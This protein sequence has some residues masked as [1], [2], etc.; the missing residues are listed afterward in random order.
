MTQVGTLRG[1]GRGGH[2]VCGTHEN[3]CCSAES[4]ADNLNFRIY[5]QIAAPTVG[6]S[7]VMVDFPNSQQLGVDLRLL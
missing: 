4:V 3:T 6:T 2:R 5:D 1:I 7:L